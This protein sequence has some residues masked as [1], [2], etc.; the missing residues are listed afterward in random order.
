[1]ITWTDSAHLLEGRIAIVSGSTGGIGASIAKQL[2]RL[3]ASVV[4]TGRSVESGRDV[5]KEIS[6]VG[7]DVKFIQADVRSPEQIN[8]LIE[9]TL[10][11]FGG[12]D[13]LVNNAAVETETKPEELDLETWHDMLDTD[14][15]AYWLTAKY[16]YPLLAKSDHAA[17]VN[18]GSNHSH[19]THPAKFPYNAIKAGIDGMTRSMATAWGVEGIRVNSVNP[20][21]TMVDRITEDMTQERMRELERIHPIGRLGAPCDVAN[22]VVFLA[23]DLAGFVTGECLVVDGGRQAVLQDDLFLQDIE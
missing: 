1:M 2:A 4:L 22:A 12:L 6:E 7:G 10:R 23:S 3:G 16:A 13:I 18:I 9:D 21:W 20:G 11:E 14:F 17:V 15:R 8:S 5:T 19:A